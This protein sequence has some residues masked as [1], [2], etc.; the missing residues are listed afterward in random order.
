MQVQVKECDDD[1]MIQLS[2]EILE[3]AGIT[4]NEV[5]DVKIS[6]G[7]ITLIKPFQHKTLEERTKECDGKLVLD[8][9]F[10]WGE[11]VG[12]EVW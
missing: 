8:T 6:G 2:K 5:L 1:Y 9:D 3:S 4:M 7:M 11:P 10:E 12:K